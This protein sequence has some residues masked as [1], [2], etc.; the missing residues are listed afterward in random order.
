VKATVLAID[1]SREML[2]SIVERLRPEGIQVLTA[3]NPATGVRLALRKVPDL[4]LLDACMPTQSGLDVCRQLKGDPRTATIPVILLTTANDMRTRIRGYDV[5]AVDILTKPMHAEILRA[6]VRASLRAKQELERFRRA[7]SIDRLTGLL[8]RAE[9][10]ERMH[11]L[12]D[13]AQKRTADGCLILIDLD[14]FKRINDGF[15]HSVG[16]I[17]LVSVARAL[18]ANVRPT[19][20]VC[21]Y[22]GEELAVIMP[23]KRASTGMEVADRLRKKIKALEIKAGTE[24]VPVTASF[25]VADSAALRALGRPLDVQSIIVAA[26]ESLYDAKRGGRNCVRGFGILPRLDNVVSSQRPGPPLT[27]VG[28]PVIRRVS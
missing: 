1:D 19:D 27:I 2:G 11:L 3:S 10:D 21:R 6:R 28:P 24:T 26:D 25:G 18:V 22:G 9:F 20:F 7:A 13:A 23:G 4:I 14:H 8:N 5:G 16:D 17:V 15:G 12:V